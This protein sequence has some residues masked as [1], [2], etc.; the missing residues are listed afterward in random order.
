MRKMISC[1]IPG[2]IL[3]NLL[4]IHSFQA[5]SSTTPDTLSDPDHAPEAH[6]VSHPKKSEDQF[7]PRSFIFHHIKDAHEWH[8]ITINGKDISIPLPVI[9][10]SK[11][12]GFH[13]FLS[14]KLQHGH[15]YRDFELPH[16][17]EYSGK[18]I[19][20][21]PNGEIYKPIDVSFTKDVATAF[22]SILLMLWLFISIANRYKGNPLA[23]PKGKQS[24]F[25]L[26][27]LFVRDEIAKPFIGDHKYKRFMPY[28]L[29][30]FFFIWIN[31]M[32]G[33]V[34]FPPGGANLTGDI[35]V[36]LTLAGFTF[37]ITTINGNKNY[38][39][40][41]F[42]TPGVPW[43]LKF[44]IPIIPTIEF[45][46]L[47]IKPITLM[48]R[49][50]ANITAGH[51]IVLSLFAMIF[52]FG[53]MQPVAG[54]GSSIVIIPFTI[55]MTFL[56]LLVALIQAYVFTMLSALYFGMATEEHHD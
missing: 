23:V 43:W 13:I 37:V 48:I 16:H 46:G 7:N 22:F 19:E 5:T 53:E 24:F 20:H 30:L 41:T 42:N 6:E 10:Y 1:R 8:I 29:T 38:W 25:E 35:S 56:E 15:S 50:F 36:T 26:F 51:I 18:I 55:F 4:F 21:L 31:N 52:I 54:Y 27:I 28:L 33:L 11:H 40:H 44:P 17:G 34:P 12:S 45:L 9:L 14:S 39:Q 47:F 3:L 32:L 2:M 49:L